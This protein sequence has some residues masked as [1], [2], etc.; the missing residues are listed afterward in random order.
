MP[1]DLFTHERTSTTVEAVGGLEDDGTL[2]A[3]LR[4]HR[5]PLQFSE[6]V[7]VRTSPKRISDPVRYGTIRSEPVRD[8]TDWKVNVTWD[9]PDRTNYSF[10]TDLRS[11]YPLE[12]Y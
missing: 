6:G 5:D 3:W 11:L 7:R 10:G 12:T 8:G 4:R 1:A 9:G 2:D